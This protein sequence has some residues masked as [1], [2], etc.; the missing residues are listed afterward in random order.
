MARTRNGITSLLRRALVTMVVAQVG[1]IASLMGI[2]AWRKRVRPRSNKFPRVEPIDVDVRDST[3]TIYTF[4]EDLYADMLAAIRGAKRKVLFE[5]YIVKNDSLGEEFKQA[6][7]EAAERGVAVH[8]VYDGFAN[9]VVPRKFFDFPPSVH[10]IRYPAL[11]V[12]LLLLN[13]RKSGRDH[14]KILVVDGE[15][16]FVGGY[17]VGALYATQW[18]DTHLRV[19][20]AAT[21]EL[22]NAFVDLWNRLRAP[23][24]PLLDDPGSSV[25]EPRIRTQR[26]VPEQLTYPIRGMYLEA[27]DRA[28]HHIYVTQAY[29]IP[30]RDILE[31]LLKAAARGVEVC[32]LV[33]EVSNH[34][35]ADWLSRGFYG[36][37]LRS[38]VQLW[39][40]QHA[41]V[42]AKTATIDGHWSTIGT[43][44][45]DRL[46]L[47]GNYEINVEIIDDG[48]A[49]EM[50]RVFEN[51][52]SNARRL[53]PD[54]WFARPIVAKASE[55]VLA[56]LRPLL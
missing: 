36:T 41:M 34:V 33:P 46:S 24:Q 3:T 32:I 14:R 30:D 54:E 37:L 52:R 4:G 1:V 42:H 50:E 35:V 38:G 45:I 25:W 56:P 17:N 11:R 12:G 43:A 6:L 7:I 55:L 22:E 18:R 26:N 16:G 23:E 39:L 20:G 31:A 29:F 8:V 28:Q 53:E 19:R 15:V 10:V 5:S 44:N 2:D 27:I 40:F 48:F 51:D 49:A 47:T 9:M 21:W 13:V